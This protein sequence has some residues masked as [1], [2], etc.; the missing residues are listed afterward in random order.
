[1][2]D[3]NAEEV[4]RARAAIARRC[5]YSMQRLLELQKADQA[6]WRRRHRAAAE[7][8]VAQVGEPQAEYSTKHPK[9]E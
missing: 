6:T 9:A 8:A 2:K 4:H 7:P 1:M 3:P 5:G